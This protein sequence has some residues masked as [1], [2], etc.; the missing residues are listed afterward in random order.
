MKEA[1]S[2]LWSAYRKY[3]FA[4]FA[5]RLL[6]WL[7]ANVLDCLSPA[8]LLHPRRCRAVI[9]EML[10]GDY[11]RVL[12]WR[13]SFGYA[14]PLFQ[15]PQHMAHALSRQRCLV[16]YEVTTAT[17]GC[18]ALRQIAPGLW[19]FNF[20]N[21]LLRRML[22]RALERSSLPRYIQL[23][24]TD[25]KLSARALGRCAKRGYG[26][27]Y[28]YID[29]LSPALSGTAALPRAITEKF[30]YAMAHREVT[31]A[32]TAE[33]LRRDVLRRRGGENLVF[34]SNGV[35]TAFFRRFDR[36]SFEPDFLSILAK[37]KPIVC[38]YGALACWFDY[39][40]VKALAA[41]GRY[42]VV[43]IGL[44]YDTSFDAQLPAPVPDLYYLGPRDYRVLKYYA[45]EAAVLMIPFLINDITR[46]TSPVKL[47][48]YMALGRPIVTTD[49]DE[50]R[51]YRS[52]L[53]GH[54]HAEFLSQVERALTLRDDPAYLAA[55]DADARA[56]DWSEK[57]AAIVEGL[58]AR[59]QG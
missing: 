42:S 27:L 26:I 20:N 12:L 53:I 33:R 7:R 23:Y 14:S 46:A 58:R 47:F 59:E 24:S 35:D 56:N 19:L 8:V 34:A 43:L 41:T 50:C 1:L 25:W 9:E 6:A 55:L 52:V 48:E 28:E 13:S 38:Y 5:S 51:Q 15:R 36:Y 45:R 54:S 2:K 57:A 37:G 44:K 18:A 29:H 11:A 21:V 16:I 49:M 32:V 4:R 3:G 10:A 17:D 30:D 39:A 22:A 31:V 40:L